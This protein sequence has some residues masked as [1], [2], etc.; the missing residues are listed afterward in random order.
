GGQ[1]RRGKPYL[2]SDANDEAPGPAGKG[3]RRKRVCEIDLRTGNVHEIAHFDE[4][5][6]AAMEGL[7]FGPDGTLRVLILA[8]SP[9]DAR[10]P[11]DSA[12]ALRAES[13]DIAEFSAGVEHRYPL[14]LVRYAEISKD[15]SLKFTAGKDAQK[16]HLNVLIGKNVEAGRL[17]AG[18]TVS[19]PGHW[20]S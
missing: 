20:T 8:P 1:V 10:F 16:R 7:A 14:Q 9:Y 2:A 11:P 13:A 3:R 12:T 4:P 17:L 5:D 6:R 19:E 18:F 15:P